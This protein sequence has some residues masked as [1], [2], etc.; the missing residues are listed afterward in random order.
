MN[1]VG[2]L[3]YRG[4]VYHLIIVEEGRIAL[5]INGGGFSK[6]PRIGCR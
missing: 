5:I 2:R 3:S 4:A 6:S 1:V